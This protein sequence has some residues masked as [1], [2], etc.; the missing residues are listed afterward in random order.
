MLINLDTTFHAGT[1]HE[2]YIEALRLLQ[3]RP[4]TIKTIVLGPVT[5]GGFENVHANLEKLHNRAQL[6]SGYGVDV[7]NIVSFHHALAHIVQLTNVEGYPHSILDKF[8][9]P[10]IT[11]G[12]FNYLT[13]LEGFQSSYGCLIEH[14]AAL[15]NRIAIAIIS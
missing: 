2:L 13:F 11:S 14:K 15:S 7:L 12:V 1:Y 3:F 8:S 4:R 6:I 5:T 9:V 10:L